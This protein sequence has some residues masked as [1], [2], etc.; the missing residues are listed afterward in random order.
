MIRLNPDI[1]SIGLVA[2]VSLILRPVFTIA[3]NEPPA[4]SAIPPGSTSRRSLIAYKYTTST[5]DPDGDSVK[6]VFDWG[7]GTTS[8]NGLD[9]IESGI[10]QSLIHKWSKEGIYQVKVMSYVNLSPYL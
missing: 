7:D 4:I 1:S 10:S 2:P 9:Y 5:I 8:W 3:D 6:Y